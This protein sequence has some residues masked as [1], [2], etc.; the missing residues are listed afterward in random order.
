MGIDLDGP[1][2]CGTFTILRGNANRMAMFERGSFDTV[3]CNSVLE[4]DPAFWRTLAE[5]GRVLRPGGLFVVGVPGFGRMNTI[6]RGADEP[7]DTKRPEWLLASAPVLGLHEFPRD[8]YR[9]SARA[10]HDVFLAGLDERE[11]REAM[12]PPRLVGAGRTRTATAA[13]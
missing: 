11:V 5:V 8:Y 3:V 9:F 4:H 12:L 1:H 6:P 10:V 2:D 13:P 7:A